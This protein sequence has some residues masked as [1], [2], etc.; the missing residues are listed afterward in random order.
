MI[1]RIL[2]TDIL[3]YF[4]RFVIQ[5]HYKI[6]LL[7]SFRG[8]LHKIHISEFLQDLWIIYK[9]LFPDPLED[10]RLWIHVSISVY[11]NSAQNINL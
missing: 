3:I 4:I 5:I 1:S 2:N 7:G 6:H 10:P 9:I 11:A 8:F